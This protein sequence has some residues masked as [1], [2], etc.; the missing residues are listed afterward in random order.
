MEPGYLLSIIL[1]AI[2]VVLIIIILVLFSKYK[3]L[4]AKIYDNV[5]L[6]GSEDHI[7]DKYFEE[8]IKSIQNKLK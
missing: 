1:A 6:P 5:Q 4:K 3:K 2:V 7:E 8:R